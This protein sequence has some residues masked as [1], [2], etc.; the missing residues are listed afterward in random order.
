MAEAGA[1]LL[2]IL[3]GVAWVLR[4]R[5]IASSHGKNAA[6]TQARFS[7][8]LQFRATLYRC[9]PGVLILIFGMF[10]AIDR[11]SQ[12]EPDWW[13]GLLFIPV[14]WVLISLLARKSWRRYKQLQQIAE[15]SDYDKALDQIPRGGDT[16]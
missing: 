16:Y 11:S 8:I 6:Q 9:V 15:K 3:G 10:Y 5:Q 1:A 2:A 12:R 4:R 14:G 7:A 13:H